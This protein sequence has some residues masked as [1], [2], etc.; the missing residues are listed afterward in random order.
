MYLLTKQPMKVVEKMKKILMVLVSVLVLFL[1]ACRYVGTVGSTNQPEYNYEQNNNYSDGLDYNNGEEPSDNYGD[2]S[3]YNNGEEPDDN[4]FAVSNHPLVGSW[5]R[6][7]SYH[8]DSD[9]TI[10]RDVFEEVPGARGVI[11]NL[12][13]DGTLTFH[14]TICTENCSTWLLEGDILVRLWYQSSPDI[15]YYYINEETLILTF[16][17]IM[18]DEFYTVQTYIRVD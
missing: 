14:N 4:D 15:S 8:V 11:M 7:S 1:V 10:L 3:D 6:I 16:L 18:G 5:K 13:N 2:G 17:P 9:G 12:N